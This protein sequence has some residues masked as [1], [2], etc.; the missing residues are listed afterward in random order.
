MIEKASCVLDEKNVLLKMRKDF[1]LMRA[2]YFWRKIFA[3]IGVAFCLV[4]RIAMGQTT[5]P[6]RYGDNPAAGRFYDLNG[7]RMYV[8]EYGSGPPLLMIHG[9]GGSIES[10]SHNIPALAQHFRVIVADS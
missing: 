2:N 10:F 6:V 3:L 8:E 5:Q 1:N 4:A 7:F 9:N